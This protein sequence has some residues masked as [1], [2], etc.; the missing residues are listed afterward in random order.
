MS[1]YS[2]KTLVGPWQ[3]QR[4][5]EQDRLEDFLEKCRS[6]D[7]A[8]QKMTKLYQAFMESTPVKMSTDGC[9]RFCESYALICPTSKPHLVQIG[10][11]NERPQTIL[12]VDSE[13]SLAAGEVLV[14]DGN[15]V[16]AS[17]CVQAV[18]RSIFQVYR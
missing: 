5:L 1:R 7:L 2:S 6:G 18:A 17:T 10:L 14:N 3:Q 13:A 16:V 11:S 9:V 15:G 4:Q 8:I 12:A